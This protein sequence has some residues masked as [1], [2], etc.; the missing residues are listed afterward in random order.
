MRLKDRKDYMVVEKV[1]ANTIRVLAFAHNVLKAD[2]IKEK[3]LKKHPKA[4][5]R[6]GLEWLSVGDELEV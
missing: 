5:V 1:A 3:L 2:E 6:F 4:E